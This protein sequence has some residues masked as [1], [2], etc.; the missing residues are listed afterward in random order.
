MKDD[1]EAKKAIEGKKDGW[2]GN[3]ETKKEGRVDR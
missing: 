2:T 1:E 3:K